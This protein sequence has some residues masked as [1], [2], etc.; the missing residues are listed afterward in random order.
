MYA[1]N[2]SMLLVYM[3]HCLPQ[4]EVYIGFVRRGWKSHCS[5]Y[6]V[7]WH[8]STQYRIVRCVCVPLCEITIKSNVPTICHFTVI[9]CEKHE[10]DLYHLFIAMALVESRVENCEWFG[11]FFALCQLCVVL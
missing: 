5:T 7:E 9:I 11:I 2:V 8:I 1:L 10:L 3:F 6:G 4:T